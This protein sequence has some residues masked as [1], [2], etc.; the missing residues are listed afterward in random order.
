MILVLV[1]FEEPVATE[2]LEQHATLC[3]RV[4]SEQYR[5]GPVRRTLFGNAV[6]HVAEWLFVDQTAFETASRSDQFRAAASDAAAI[7]VAHSV[8]VID[9]DPQVS[10]GS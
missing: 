6:A 1:T 3:R 2:R 9:L 7:G 8:H 5:H 4:Q 10:Q